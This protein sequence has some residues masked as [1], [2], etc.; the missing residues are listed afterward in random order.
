MIDSLG[1]VG[2]A[3]NG[4]NRRKPGTAVRATSTRAAVP[5]TRLSVDRVRAR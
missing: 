1:D 2:T 5:T 3:L 4:A